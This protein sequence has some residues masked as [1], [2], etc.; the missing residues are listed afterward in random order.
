MVLIDCKGEELRRGRRLGLA[1]I[2]FSSFT[3]LGAGGRILSCKADRLCF[4]NP[5]L[6]D[7][8]SVTL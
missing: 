1:L 6:V 3:R 2:G 7:C 4:S 5:F 8:I